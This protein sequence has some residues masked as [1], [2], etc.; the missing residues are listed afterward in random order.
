[1]MGSSRRIRKVRWNRCSGSGRGKGVRG[2][3]HGARLIRVLLVIMY[4]R[5]NLIG[6]TI[7]PNR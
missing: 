2:G 3:G 6:L 7:R 4:D 5:R 1:M